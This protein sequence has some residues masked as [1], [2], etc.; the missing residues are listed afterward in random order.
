MLILIRSDYETLLQGT[1]VTNEMEHSQ[2][3]GIQTM[4]RRW[5]RYR[6]RS[7]GLPI[8]IQ[9]ILLPVFLLAI[10]RISVSAR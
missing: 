1:S 8:R 10:V 2:Q 9:L 6:Y 3:I 4:I 5:G 7:E